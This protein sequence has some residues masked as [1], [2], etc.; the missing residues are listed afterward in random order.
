MSLPQQQPQSQ[1]QAQAIRAYV[2]GSFQ[3]PPPSLLDDLAGGRVS[4]LGVV[5][6]MGEHLTSQD[7][8]QRTRAVQLLSDI[9]CH[10]L[11]PESPAAAPAS[12]IF[13]VQA[14]RTLTTFFADKISDSI[15]ISENFIRSSK[16]PEV[17]P[18][19]APRARRNEAEAKTLQ[20][21]A[22]LVACL[23]ALTVL[24]ACHAQQPPPPPGHPAPV[25][26]FGSEQAHA[27]AEAL[28]G[29]V[30]A[31]DHPQSL[32]F[33]VY[34]LLDSLV[35]HHRSS[36]KSY[37]SSASA[38]V[39]APASDAAAGAPMEEDSS[40]DGNDVPAEAHAE[41]CEGK[42]FLRGYVRMVAGEKDP[43]NLMVL[44][45]VDKVLLTEWQMDR[46]MTEA[47]FDITFCYFPITFRPPPDDPY[48]ITSD[49]LKQALRAALCASPA[50]A[51]L[52]YPLLLEKLSA[53]GGPA[54]LDTLR[55]LIAAMPVYGR[56]AAEAN[57]KRLWEGL[58]IE[59]F[60]AID[61]ETCDL[62][63]D[64][65]TTLVHVLY[66]GV[67]PPEGIAGRMV[68]DCLVE[69]EEPGKSL[70]KAAIKVLGCLVRAASS[71]AYLA[72]YG[73][74]DQ[75]M[76]MFAEP[77]DL[78][79]RAP[80]LTG[81]GE[82]LESLA[83]VYRATERAAA[84]S[85]E[86]SA[87]EG[88]GRMLPASGRV[89]SYSGDNRPL[90]PF[91]ADLL[92]SL[93]N[94]LR[95]T[96]YRRSALLAY[97]SVLSISI[98]STSTATLGPYASASAASVEAQTKPFLSIDETAFLTREVAQL[99]T[100]AIGD[101]VREEALCAIEVVANE[102]AAGKG[103]SSRV[104][105]EVVLPV[106]LKDLPETMAPSQYPESRTAGQPIDETEALLDVSKGR[107]RRS[108]G[109]IS[110]LCVAPHLFD[111][112]VVKL[113]TK[114]ELCC[115]PLCKLAE[116]YG[117]DASNEECKSQ[118]AVE[119]EVQVLEEAN[120]GYARGLLLTLQT[121]LDEK[122]QRGH[123]DLAKYGQT[124]PP[125]LA[126]LVLSGLEAM[127]DTRI[128]PSLRRLGIGANAHVIADGA[129]L[130]GTL[131]KALDAAK[132]RELLVVLNKTFAEGAVP[133]PLDSNNGDGSLPQQGL[134]GAW[135][136]PSSSPL[137]NGVYRPFETADNADAFQAAQRDSLALFAA[138][139]VASG[140]EAG[141]PS[142][143]AADEPAGTAPSPA[144]A[145]ARKLIRWTLCSGASELQAR[146][147]MWMLCS[148]V[149]KHVDDT[150][151]PVAAAWESLADD[152]WRT[153]VLP[154]SS[155]PGDAQQPLPT[156]G[157]WLR[158]RRALQIWMWLARG[159]SVKASKQ[160]DRMVGR[161]LDEIFEASA[162]EGDVD[163][164]DPTWQFAK[165]AA[166]L[167]EIV[168]RTEDGVVTKANGFT[169]RLLARQRFFSSLLPRLIRGNDA[170]SPR[171]KTLYLI[172][173]SS[174]LPF[175][176]PQTISDQLVSLFPMLIQSLSLPDP[177]A[178]ASAADGILVAVEVGRRVRAAPSSA[179]AAALSEAAT[180]AASAVAKPV[181]PT[182]LVL[183]HL[184]TLIRRLLDNARE[185]RYAVASTRIA[186]LRALA[187]IAASL[188]A[189]QV[190]RYKAEVLKAL[191]APGVG[192]D[193][194][195]R[196]VR[197]FAVDCREAWFDVGT[198]KD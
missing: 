57:A 180:A 153:E 1:P 26:G 188:E 147:G 93:Q 84:G 129:R 39:A 100:S 53:A 167:L 67:D 166:R 6:L 114:L 116:I 144:L 156:E 42:D 43:R 133:T 149:N 172:A 174:L 193:D 13:T 164:V 168:A 142:V 73:F 30:K 29:H 89:R 41:R 101:D 143:P 74:M 81:V 87:A 79:M 28:F 56:A 68:R 16:A 12:E 27:V 2:V 99:L 44:F 152:F 24:S 96:S 31:N 171:P 106:L 120:I 178:R 124:L 40:D 125:R 187:S 182:E 155:A 162:A 8:Q 128:A 62:S 65:L 111:E 122:K 60:H 146:A 64:A 61:D 151:A 113:F 77:A 19:T 196:K 105:E 198:A 127:A 55:T 25:K 190:Q 123:R 22:M 139:V 186:S 48:G 189:G 11:D 121:L 175:L 82:L 32:R 183:E 94:G 90:D 185:G 15:V 131:V 69:L 80:I 137:G 173:L 160:G 108:L 98:L 52:G 140:K 159:F 195:K 38:D 36:L 35:A 45:G 177:R 17:L 78:S 72:I 115:V 70:A 20:G 66:D 170:S 37:R 148:C 134:G 157:D 107:I 112:V 51:P 18:E 97:S 46:E 181:D 4:L 95:S 158:R 145:F 33:L 169:L 161:V 179:S 103:S 49:D 59:I 102:R 63:C 135:L 163:D 83:K 85:A 150:Q 118:E 23:K 86:D 9:A 76:K 109:A 176:P 141:I 50:M 47:F 110:R 192:I 14:V 117:V 71:T 34:R 119:E 10:F 130:L 54:K 191:A 184:S 5:R 75:M 165:T 88:S 126:V 194:A 104:I 154:P 58:K 138:A 136:I 21:S 132:Q 197:E 7:E 91:L 3:E 92:S